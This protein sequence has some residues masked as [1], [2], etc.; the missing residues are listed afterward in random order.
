MGTGGTSSNRIT[1]CPSEKTEAR[2]VYGVYHFVSWLKDFNNSV[3]YSLKYKIDLL[4][5][6]KSN[7]CFI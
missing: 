2:I 6:A 7:S 4:L 5:S 3:A 1:D